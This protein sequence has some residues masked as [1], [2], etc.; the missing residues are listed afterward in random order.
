MKEIKALKQ[1]LLKAARV[2]VSTGAGMSAESGV[3]T[4]RGKDGLWKNFR[5]EEL[6]TVEA[7]QRDPNLVWEWYLW[8]RAK[9]LE[10]S[11]NGGHF[12]L[13]ELASQVPNFTLV[14]QNV[15]DLHRRAGSTDI[16]ELHGNIMRNNCMD[17]GHEDFTEVK[18]TNPLCPVCRSGMYRPGVVWFGESLPQ[19]T[20]QKAF[21]ASAD[22]DFFLCVGSSNIVY[23]AASLPQVAKEEGAFLVEI[24]P[25]ETNLSPIF[26]LSLRGTAASVLPQLCH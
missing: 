16:L 10:S 18:Q 5:A 8:R 17:C 13:V 12:S 26:D 20:L 23:P 3:P 19:A 6:A 25:E 1:K 15:D 14:T 21:D 11:P 7:F 22:C 2:V 24:N 4:F 9:I